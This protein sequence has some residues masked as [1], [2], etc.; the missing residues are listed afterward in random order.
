MNKL[1]VVLL[2]LSSF[3]IS[4]HMI[5]RVYTSSPQN[6]KVLCE[7][8][9]D[10]AAARAGQWYDIVADRTL[11]DRII[12]SG[13]TYEVRVPD[14][15][16]AKEKV[17]AQYHSYDEVTTLLRN[18]ASSYPSICKL[19]SLPLCTYQGRWLYGVKISD[20]P[21][22]EDPNEP[23][24]LVDALHHSREWATIELVLF[25]ADSMLK[26]Y[27]VVPQITNIINSTEIYCFPIINADGYAYD[28]P[29]QH[30]WRLNRE[31]FGGQTGTDPN[32]NY[33]GCAAI[34]GGDWGAVDNGKATHYPGDETFCGAWPNSGDE[35]R[36]L[37]LYAKSHVINA[38]M[39]YHSY[40]EYLMWGWGFTTGD[41]PDATLCAQKG[42]YMASLI[43]RLGGGTYL[44]GQIPEILYSVSGGSI[45]WLYSWNHYVNGISN[46][47]YTTEVGTSFY[48]PLSDVDNIVR[49]NFK[50]LKYLA[51]FCDSIVL[52]CEGQV[53]PPQIYSHDTVAQ[54]FS[55][56]W[57][58]KNT[59]DNHPVQWELVELSNLS[60]KTDSLESGTT[61]WILNGYTLSTAQSHSASHSFFSGNSNNINNA[62]QT[63]HPYLVQ[64]GDSFTF[65][66]RYTLENN[67]DVTVP[68]VSENTREW[69]LVDTV[70]RYTGTQSSWVRRAYSLASWVGKS[71]Y[72]RFRTMYD[73]GTTSGGFYVDDIRPVPYF[74]SVSTVSSNITDT[75][76]A[77]SNHAVGEYYFY[78]RGNNTTW[79]WGDYSCLEYVVVSTIGVAEHKSPVEETRAFSLMLTPNPFSRSLAINF[80]IQN[81]KSEMSLWIFDATGRLVK[82][83]NHLTIQS[84]NQVIW[85]GSDDLGHPVKAGV[86][87]VR[88]ETDGAQR[89]E[90]A[91]LLR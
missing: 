59:D 27:G 45:D 28:Y 77:F 38:Y 17:R 49:Q 5:V 43:T 80:A 29:G 50:A 81:P 22:I 39:S 40:A 67:Y 14:V 57:H 51:D 72:F 87:F 26:S 3:A 79:G 73:G 44:P 61:R 63:V 7:K 1:A 85:D 86:Y 32:R 74:N 82:S 88:L 42:N 48:Q 70:A 11:M 2:V 13:L 24:F 33:P 71:V 18:M 34:L 58:A 62:A 52:L 37:T 25:F 89:T 75:T 31:P 55:L 83:F 23:G 53:P 8:N 56:A 84:V 4:Q 20:E 47:S 78:V 30:M 19:D 60:V 41:I 69:Y 91:V 65:W 15:D 16:Y 9:L 36:A 90:K 54:N 21:N 46:L 35:T 76:Y 6:L 12:N 66:C 64:P 10:I 68:E